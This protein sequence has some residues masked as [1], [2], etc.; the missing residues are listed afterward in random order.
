MR[1]V[2]EA[3]E[4]SEL[5]FSSNQ[6]VT[7]GAATSAGGG[8]QGVRH[9]LGAPRPVRVAVDVVVPQLPT[10]GERTPDQKFWLEPE[11]PALV[12]AS[13]LQRTA[14][15]CRRGGCSSCATSGQLGCKPGR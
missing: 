12:A 4:N 9:R 1:V 3:D 8:G 13:H 6:S 11:L 15:A 14:R 7:S 2:S 5:D 10:P